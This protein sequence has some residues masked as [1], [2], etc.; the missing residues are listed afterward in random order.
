MGETQTDVSQ[1]SPADTASES[2]GNG[3]YQ[4]VCDKCCYYSQILRAN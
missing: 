4:S 2:T 1:L 3:K